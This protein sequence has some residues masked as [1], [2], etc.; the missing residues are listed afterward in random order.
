MQ[1]IAYIILFSCAVI[2]FSNCA[3]GKDVLF[4]KEPPFKVKAAFF[5]NWVAGVKE[6]GSGTNVSIILGS[7]SEEIDVREI[8]YKEKVANAIQ[9]PQNIDKYTGFFTNELNRDVIMDE[10]TMNEAANTPPVKSPFS[11]SKNEAV[12]SYLHDG[13]MEYFKILNVEEKPMIAYPGTSPN[14]NN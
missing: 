10:D 12:I 8:Y 2:S 1:K 14:G 5:Q 3:S 13:E 4:V 11:L 9:D 6:G 7:I